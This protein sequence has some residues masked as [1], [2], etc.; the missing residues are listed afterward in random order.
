[1]HDTVVKYK[2]GN[3][4][5]P[6]TQ[7]LHTHTTKYGLFARHEL[8]VKLFEA[9]L[10]V[11]RMRMPVDILKGGLEC[12][13]SWRNLKSRLFVFVRKLGE[14]SEELRNGSKTALAKHMVKSKA[15]ISELSS[16][17]EMF[18]ESPPV[19]A[20]EEARAVQ[21]ADPK[22]VAPKD[23][24]ILGMSNFREEGGDAEIKERTTNNWVEMMSN[25]TNIVMCKGNANLGA[26]INRTHKLAQRSISGGYR[27]CIRFNVSICINKHDIIPRA[28]VLEMGYVSNNKIVGY[29]GGAGDDDDEIAK[30]ISGGGGGGRGSSSD[31][32]A[33]VGGDILT[34]KENRELSELLLAIGSGGSSDNTL[35]RSR[36]RNEETDNNKT[37]APSPPKKSKKDDDAD[38][39]ATKN[40]TN[41]MPNGDMVEHKEERQQQ[42][43]R[44]EEDDDDSD[45]V[46]LMGSRF[47]LA[48][49][50]SEDFL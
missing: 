22:S 1:M 12:N 8:D 11:F 23:A 15:A 37:D 13:L 18:F 40:T 19:P 50:E 42:L 9:W 28:T 6:T 27:C 29:V 35:K 32:N 48:A 10:S 4:N 26:G 2:L 45:A 24:L 49:D 16:L 46:G 39:E 31:S 17:A 14:F 20:V 34:D 3:V 44:E 36:A 43:Q 25:L 41:A 38:E 47:S 5:R 21:A 7:E 30:L 33:L